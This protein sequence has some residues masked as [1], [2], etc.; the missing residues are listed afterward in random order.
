[1]ERFSVNNFSKI[2]FRP[3]DHLIIRYMICYKNFVNNTF[4]VFKH[5]GYFNKCDIKVISEVKKT[6]CDI[7]G[8]WK[9]TTHDKLWRTTR[10][11]LKQH[12]QTTL[13]TKNQ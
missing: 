7:S 6:Q 9:S 1:M 13:K 3:K 4:A 2:I 8:K 12:R 11:R 10:P 5:S